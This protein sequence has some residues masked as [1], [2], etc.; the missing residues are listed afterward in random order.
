MMSKGNIRKKV[1]ISSRIVFMLLLVSA[2]LF[3]SACGTIEVRQKISKDGKVSGSIDINMDLTS[4]YVSL[5]IPKESFA[6]MDA[7]MFTQICENATASMNITNEECSVKNGIVAL[8][9]NLSLNKNDEYINESNGFFKKSG[10]FI[11]EYLYTPNTSTMFSGSSFNSTDLDKFKAS[12]LKMN[13]V[14]EMPGKIYDV[15]GGELIH[16]DYATDNGAAIF[17]MLNIAPG[18]YIGVRSREQNSSIF[19]VIILFLLFIIIAL[20]FVRL[21]I[22]RKQEKSQYKDKPGTFLFVLLMP[23]VALIFLVSV[24]GFTTSDNSG[25][26]ILWAFIAFMMIL[27][28]ITRAFSYL[29]TD[30]ELAGDGIIYKTCFIKKTILFS[31]IKK[32]ERAEVGLLP[33]NLGKGYGYKVATTSGEEISPTHLEKGNKQIWRKGIL[34]FLKNGDAVYYP[35]RDIGWVIDAVKTHI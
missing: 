26:Q 5:G 30:F 21:I 3:L 15:V 34:I 20:P 8:S 25:F 17:D 14:V 27:S 13:I 6:E 22:H 35:V 10:F 24:G 32:I 33:F 31:E 16:E 7:A 18:E 1:H 4:F 2:V 28:Y 12:G 23:F 11:T 29:S 9:G 19:S